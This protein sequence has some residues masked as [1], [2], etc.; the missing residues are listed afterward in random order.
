MGD[1]PDKDYEDIDSRSKKEWLD[2]LER[3]KRELAK[4][5]EPENKNPEAVPEEGE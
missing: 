1:E 3:T 2:R 5:K 4:E